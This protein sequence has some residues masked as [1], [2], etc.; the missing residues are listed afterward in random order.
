MTI[1][2]YYRLTI[3]RFMCYGHGENR[4]NGEKMREKHD[5]FLFSG[6]MTKEYKT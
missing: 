1:F 4:K 6:T 3:A 2:S 5:R